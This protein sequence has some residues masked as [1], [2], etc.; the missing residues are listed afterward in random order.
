MGEFKE[1]EEEEE[2]KEEQMLEALYVWGR[3]ARSYS[4]TLRSPNT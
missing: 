4:R 1:E 2:G 3:A